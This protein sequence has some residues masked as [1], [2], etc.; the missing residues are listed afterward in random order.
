MQQLNKYRLAKTHHFYRLG[1]I[2]NRNGYAYYY[3]NSINLRTNKRIS[4]GIAFCTENKELLLSNLIRL[5][6]SEITKTEIIEIKTWYDLI[7]NFIKTHFNN[8]NREQKSRFKFVIQLFLKD[9]YKLTEIDRIRLE[10]ANK[11]S[12]LKN[13]YEYTTLNRY[14][15]YLNQIFKFGL[16]ENYLT[17]LPITQSMYLKERKKEIELFTLQEIN[18]IIGYLENNNKYYVADMIKFIRFSGLRFNEAYELQI[19]DVKTDYI[20]VFGKGSINR[21]IPLKPFPELK[22]TLKNIILKQY[23][24]KY[25]FKRISEQKYRIHLKRAI[26]YLNINKD[27]SFHSLRKFRENELIHDKRLNIVIISQLLGHTVK[28]MQQHYIKALNYQE[29]S[30]AILQENK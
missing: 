25:L 26:N 5:I 6:E 21:Q 19:K 1:Y 4:S 29:L 18:S 2:Y 12:V 13:Q 7:E 27:I 17:K 11:I 24:N 9:N 22:E 23:D 3:I 20:D 10:I 16:T 30:N 15:K 8:F 28:I 14:L